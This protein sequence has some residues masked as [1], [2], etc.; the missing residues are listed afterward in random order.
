M[1]RAV[2]HCAA[3]ERAGEVVMPGFMVEFVTE[4]LQSRVE[5]TQIT[6]YAV[7]NSGPSLP[8]VFALHFFIRHKS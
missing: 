3:I 5:R 2:E 4:L 7:P 1:V 8:C 6:D